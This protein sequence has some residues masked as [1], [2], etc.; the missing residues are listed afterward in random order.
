MHVDHT[1]SFLAMQHSTVRPMFCTL[2]CCIDSS[3]KWCACVQCKPGNGK[4]G[5]EMDVSPL[6]QLWALAKFELYARDHVV[7]ALLQRCLTVSSGMN[8][9]EVPSTLYAIAKMQMDVN[10]K[11]QAALMHRAEQVASEMSPQEVA[12][13]LWAL[14]EADITPGHELNAAL[15]ARA[16]RIHRE[17]G[18]LDVVQVLHG[19]ACSQSNRSGAPSRQRTSA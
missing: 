11:L 19:S 4:S 7:E 2:L 13:R 6:K 14:A 8:A 18:H 12:N 5:S 10:S 1:S 3:N 9:Q 17:F 16:A 15:L